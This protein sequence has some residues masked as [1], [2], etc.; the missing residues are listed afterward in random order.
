MCFTAKEFESELD[1]DET[2]KIFL[3]SYPIIE[4]YTVEVDGDLLPA[5]SYKVNKRTGVITLLKSA[6]PMG[7]ANVMVRG[8][9][10]HKLVPPIVQ[11]I[12]TLIV[13]KTALSARFG[14]LIDSE[15]LGD[16]SQSRTFK[17]LND[18]LDRAWDALGRNCRI[19]T[20]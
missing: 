9:R 17:K 15:H 3:D 12:A 8:I 5:R 7:T 2:N 6:T 20:I 14:P 16:F 13:A 1:G 4:I 10:G 11:K 19:Y 18:E